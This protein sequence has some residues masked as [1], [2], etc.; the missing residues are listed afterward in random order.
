MFGEGAI[1]SSESP[2]SSARGVR[3]LGVSETALFR[4]PG[5]GLGDFSAGCSECLPPEETRGSRVEVVL[6]GG[7]RSCFGMGWS[8]RK[9]GVA[10]RAWVFP[11]SRLASGSGVWCRIGLRILSGVRDRSEF[12]GAGDCLHPDL[13]DPATAEPVLFRLAPEERVL[14]G[15]LPELPGLESSL[16][17]LRSASAGS[18]R[19]VTSP[20]TS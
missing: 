7:V 20:T 3:E 9:V 6:E 12:L 14:S 15:S 18:C 17:W 10:E 11:L 5:L 13:A 4:I 1:S 8:A 19:T 2:V 16:C